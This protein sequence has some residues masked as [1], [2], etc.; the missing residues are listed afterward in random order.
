MKRDYYEILGVDR[1]ASQEEIKKAYRRLALKYHP[2]RNQG[3]KEAEERFKEVVEAYSVLSDP[4]K[5]KLY[6]LYGHEGVKGNVDFRTGWEDIFSEFDDFFS[7]FFNFTSPGER[8]RE[9]GDDIWVEISISLEEAARGVEREVEVERWSQCPN[10]GGSGAE[11]G[12]GLRRCPV[13]GGRGRV[14][15]GHLFIRFTRTCPRCGGRGLVPEEPCRICRGAGFVR[16]RESIKIRIPAGIEDGSRLVLRG[17]GDAG[18]NGSPRGDLYIVV[19]VREHPVFKRKGT[20]LYMDLKVDY[21]TAILGGEIKI[22]DLYGEAFV[23]EIPS[24]TQPGTM[25]M[26]KDRGLREMGG[27]RKGALFVRVNVEIPKK[28]SRKEREYL[29]K[30]K[31]LKERKRIYNN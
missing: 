21:L 25:L 10:C 12:T 22:K 17:E 5:R 4:E 24:G 13:C 11:P 31:E 26:I 30:L 14:V 16:Q 19:R 15:E 20:N 1:S 18:K 29:E 28:L 23:L 27:S 9:R 2:D 7:S 6:D 8:R 3:S